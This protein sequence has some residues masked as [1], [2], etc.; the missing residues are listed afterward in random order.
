MAT[1]FADAGDAH[2]K[3]KQ[4]SILDYTKKVTNKDQLEIY[5]APGGGFA[6]K[7]ERI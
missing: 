6:I 1:V 4:F 7:I 3:D 2:Y 5:M